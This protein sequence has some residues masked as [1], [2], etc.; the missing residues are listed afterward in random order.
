MGEMSD[1]ELLDAFSGTGAV[2][3][4]DELVRRHIGKVRGMIY[5][6]VLNDADA[7][8]I[9]QE[10]FL[11]VMN[12]ISRFKRRSSFSTWLYRIVMNT[13][14]TFLTRRTRNPLEHRED[15]PDQP[16]TAR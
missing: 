14:H 13:T 7:D 11:R 4:F 12:G 10:V 9:T 6:M 1:D 16:Y 8:D 3:H 5:P 15:P 2:R